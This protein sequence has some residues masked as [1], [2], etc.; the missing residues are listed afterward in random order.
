MLPW[1][2][3][4]LK[5]MMTPEIMK[6]KANSGVKRKKSRSPDQS[7]MSNKNL[8]KNIGE[9]EPCPT[10]RVGRSVSL[11]RIETKPPYETATNI[12]SQP[13]NGNKIPQFPP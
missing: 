4:A 7:S 2:E 10:F 13:Q 1:P 11:K 6:G 5:Q 8:S 12:G 9:S 3:V